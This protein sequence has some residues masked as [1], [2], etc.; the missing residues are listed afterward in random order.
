MRSVR[1][2]SG[3]RDASD[4]TV[5]GNAE[6]FHGE[7]VAARMPLC[8][9]FPSTWK[10]FSDDRLYRDSGSVPCKLFTDTERLRSTRLVTSAS[11]G[12]ITALN[13]LMAR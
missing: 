6:I 13:W 1:F 4:K 9:R 2:E 7:E 11:P 12:G 3:E 8:S 5:V 10:T